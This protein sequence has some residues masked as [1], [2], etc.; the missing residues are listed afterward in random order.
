ML[1]LCQDQGVGVI[2][3][4]PL[5]RGRL[6]RPWGSITDRQSTDR[7]IGKWYRQQHD[8]DRRTVAAVAEVAAA[9]DVPM[10][11]VALAWLRQQPAVTAPIVGV[12]RADQLRQAIAGV[13]LVLTEEELNQVSAH[14][15]PRLPEH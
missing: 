7:M 15:T 6:A 9:R 5:A 3:W 14:Y 11:Q 13:D 1:P 2:P 4:S 12:T 10:A 8:S